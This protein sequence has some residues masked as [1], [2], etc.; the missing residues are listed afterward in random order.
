[1]NISL[2]MQSLFL[3]IGIS[4]IGSC[5][6]SKHSSVTV[7][8]YN[9]ENLFDTIDDPIT[10]D[11]E[12]TPDGK[13]QWDKERFEIKTE[14]LAR[15]IHEM[16]NPELLGLAEVENAAVLEAL[17]AKLKG[18]REAYAIAHFE[19]P[20][21]RGIDVALLYRQPWELLAK[22]R[23]RVDGQGPESW[24][25]R[26]I[27]HAKLIKTDG[28]NLHVFVNHWP[29]RSGGM[30][31]SE[32]RRLEASGRL[33]AAILELSSKDPDARILVMGDFND[34]PIDR[35]LRLLTDSLFHPDGGPLL[36][37]PCMELQQE[38]LGSYNYRGNWQMLD[39]I[40]LSRNFQSGKGRFLE[41]GVHQRTWMMYEDKRNGPVPNRTYGG[42]QYFG[43]ISDHLPV[44]ARF[45][46]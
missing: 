18:T 38:G 39:Q 17:C 25:S 12:F 41:A 31:A 28:T 45:Q 33:R 16:G 15:V 10:D 11:T 44:F 9:V 7:A 27:L 24:R 43:G 2:R 26:D 37:N 5:N 34:L 20:D 36:F 42:P 30:Q 19:S 23:I 3:F 32:P 29:S 35:S 46:R 6:L 21:P 13:L 14:K 22:D 40:L 1:M 4:C 8:F